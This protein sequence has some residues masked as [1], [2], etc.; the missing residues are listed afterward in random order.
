MNLKI[1]LML[2]FFIATLSGLSTAQELPEK[3]VGVTI[4]LPD[5]INISVE[6]KEIIMVKNHNDTPGVNDKLELNVMFNLTSGNQ[7]VK[8]FSTKKTINYYSKSGMGSINISS[9]GNYSL[10]ASIEP[11]NYFDAIRENDQTCKDITVTDPLYVVNES[12]FSKNTS[13][14]NESVEINTSDIFLQEN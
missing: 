14:A 3:D 1:F 4:T 6:Y 12:N 7:T 13:V 5:K 9:P 10:C 2:V 11:L 8:Y